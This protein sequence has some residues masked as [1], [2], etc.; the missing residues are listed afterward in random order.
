VCEEQCNSNI[1][2]IG[3]FLLAGGDEARLDTEFSEQFDFRDPAIKRLEFN[4]IRKRV[5]AELIEKHGEVCHWH[6]HLDCSKAKIW[7][8]DH[9]I[10]LS[11]NELNKRLR[12]MVSVSNRKVP[13]QSFGS[14]HPK[15][16]V[17]SCKR[18]S[19]FKKHRIFPLANEP[20]FAK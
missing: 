11:T 12:R 2:R 17:L 8:L 10:P 3:N 9:T 1:R 13:S 5:L 7:E 4:K 16:L 15:N 14:N 18:C 19:A 20:L 6:L